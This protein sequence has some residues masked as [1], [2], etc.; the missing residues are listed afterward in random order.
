[1]NGPRL[2]FS[3][4]PDC[5]P[6]HFHARPVSRGYH[7]PSTA[8]AL[9]SQGLRAETRLTLGPPQ[10]GL[11]HLNAAP[12]LPPR[13]RRAAPPR[14]DVFA[15][16]TVFGSPRDLPSRG[17]E[18]RTGLFAPRRRRPGARVRPRGERSQGGAVGL[19]CVVAAH[20]SSASAGDVRRA[21]RKSSRRVAL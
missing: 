20:R 4:L 3:E 9:L 17:R 8:H 16:A 21:R 18:P 19:R 13:R 7:G 12:D 14:L 10:G 2:C 5:W 15:R 1:A 6:A 11:F